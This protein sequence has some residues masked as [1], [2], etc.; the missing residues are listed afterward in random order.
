MKI[1]KLLQLTLYLL[2]QISIC[3]CA[4]VEPLSFDVFYSYLR[5]N[6]IEISLASFGEM[7]YFDNKIVV[8]R[9][10]ENESRTNFNLSKSNV[11]TYIKYNINLLENNDINTEFLSNNIYVLDVKNNVSYAFKTE[12]KDINKKIKEIY[13]EMDLICKAIESYE[14]IEESREPFKLISIHNFDYLNVP[15]CSLYAT[16]YLWK[17][18][19]SELSS[20]YI[21]ESE[22]EFNP[23][24][25]INYGSNGNYSNWLNLNNQFKMIMSI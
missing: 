14:R 12:T 17:Y 18:R 1:K 7:P 19:F 20:F 8:L 13:E 10:I 3:S 11:E 21:L 23:G 5:G 6:A 9:N 16:F 15:Y 4:T 24:S 2:L 25:K 22:I